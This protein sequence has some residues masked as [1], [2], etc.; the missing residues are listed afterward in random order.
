M[1]PQVV[2]F[3]LLVVAS[4]GGF[5]TGLWLR[6]VRADRLREEERQWLESQAAR[7]ECLSSRIHAAEELARYPDLPYVR[8]AGLLCAPAQPQQHYVNDYLPA[9]SRALLRFPS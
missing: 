8:L 4:L 1:S 3:A 5:V 6:R 9:E 7:L 2:I